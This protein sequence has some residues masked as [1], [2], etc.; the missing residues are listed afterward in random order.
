M[1]FTCDRLPDLAVELPPDPR[2]TPIDSGTAVDV[3]AD[4]SRVPPDSDIAALMGRWTKGLLDTAGQQGFGALRQ[5]RAAR[6]LLDHAD[7]DA[8]VPAA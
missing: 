7:G 3:A 5:R 1:G 8:V 2:F 4:F 6:F